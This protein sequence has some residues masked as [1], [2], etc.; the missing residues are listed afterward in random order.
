MRSRTP[1]QAVR[2]LA[3]QVSGRCIADSD[4]ETSAATAAELGVH[5]EPTDVA[6]PVAVRRL[7]GV[8]DARFGRLHVLVNNAGIAATA[9]LEQLELAAWDRVL[10]V[11]LRGAFLCAQAATPLLRRGA[12]GGAIINIASTRA[13]MSEP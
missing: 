11:N 12:G 6:D 5:S 8:I 13:L 4:R 9:P 10:A 7:F 1:G 2:C 3:V